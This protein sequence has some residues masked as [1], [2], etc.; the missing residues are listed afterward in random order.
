MSEVKRYELEDIGP[1]YHKRTEMVL[2]VDGCWVDYDDY[3][4]LKAQR[5]SLA[6]ENA[7]MKSA[8]LQEFLRLVECMNGDYCDGNYGNS[9]EWIRHIVA[10][11]NDYEEKFGD[12]PWGV[13]KGSKYLASESY[14]NSVRAEGVEMF[15]NGGCAYEIPHR[16]KSL[17][18]GFANQLRAGEPS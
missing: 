12:T 10:Q 15:A 9:K 6:A 16:I 3:A 17:L 1:T 5:D 18:L 4:E 8:E 2:S 11:Q 13:V 7:A 14:L